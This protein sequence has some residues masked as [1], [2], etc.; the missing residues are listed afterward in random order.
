M[1]KI[2]AKDSFFCY[3]LNNCKEQEEYI[4]ISLRELVVGAN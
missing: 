1:K 3:T 2:I 4:F